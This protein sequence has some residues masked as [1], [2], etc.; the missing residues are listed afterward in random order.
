[1]AAYQGKTD[2]GTYEIIQML[3]GNS[4]CNPQASILIAEKQSYLKVLSEI[5]TCGSQKCEL[6]GV[7]V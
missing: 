7:Y 6:E 1:M 3:L 4:S 5:V 2:W